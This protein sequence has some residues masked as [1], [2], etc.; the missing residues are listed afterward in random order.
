MPSLFG[1]TW[2][3]AT[4]TLNMLKSGA[5]KAPD[6]SVRILNGIEKDLQKE[7]IKC[8]KRGKTLDIEN[9]RKQIYKDN[10][11]KELFK[12]L[13]IDHKIEG[14]LIKYS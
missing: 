12:Y 3:T 9:L 14:L 13:N 8:A 7:K 11:Y 1:I 5:L 6:L 2:S 10:H 4:A